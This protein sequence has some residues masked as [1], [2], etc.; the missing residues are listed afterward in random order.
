MNKNISQIG[1]QLAGIWKQLGL[2]QRISVVMA[3]AVT[4]LGLVGLA[5][6]SSRVDYALLYGKLDETEASK[7]IAALDEAKVPYKISRAGGAILVPSDKVYQLRM[8][9]AGK[10]IPRGEGVGF[11][12]FDKANFGISD[13]VQRANY[14]RAVQGE[15]AR[16]ISQLDQVESARVM[17]VMPEN[18]LL[19]DN[20]RKP[21]AS[22]FVRVKG[23]GQLP[24]SAVNSI[25]FLVANSVEG[26]QANNVSVVDNQGNVLSENQE[27]DSVAGL[28]G[29]Q[30]SARR[31]FEQY[32]TKKAE[33]MLEKVLGPGQAVV[34]VSA[35]INW[36]TITRTE[37]KFDPDGQVVRSSTINDE[38]TD[39][40]TTQSS[41]GAPGLAANSNTVV[42]SAAT[43]RMRTNAPVPTLNSSHTRKKV[44]NASY[45]INKT[46]SNI[47]QAAGGLKRISSAVFIAEKFDGKG[48]DRKAVPRTPEE[49][50]KIKRIVQS[51][52]GI[53]ENGD[54]N[55][56]D[57]ITLEEMPFNDQVSAEGDQQFDKQERLQFWLDLGK[58]LVYPALGI[59]F[60]FLFWRALKRI[61]VDDIPLGVPIG[62]GNGNGNG[63]GHGIGHGKG[64]VV[65]VEVL[66]QLIREN[67]ANMTQA[68]R[69]WLTK[70]NAANQPTE[71]PIMA[72]RTTKLELEIPAIEIG[73]MTKL[74]KLAGLLIIL[75]PESAAGILKNLNEHEQEAVSQEMAK[76][77]VISQEMQR[78]ILREFSEVAVQAST[79]VLGGVNYAKIVLEKSV[80]VF[81]AS[82]IISRVAPAPVPVASMQQ[83]IDMDARQLCNMLKNEQPQTIALIVSYFPPEK[84]SQ[85]LVLLRSELRDQVVERLATL[86]AYAG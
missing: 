15:L 59:L 56:K 57:E 51:A 42:R 14:T 82:D 75:G 5:Y 11:E 53:Q 18:R 8:Q 30:L 46:T 31:N 41:G 65:T 17:I 19:T 66:N 25:R 48:A 33:G 20:Q 73:K 63:N 43:I 26:L 74:Q 77:T 72:N 13:F 9:M 84:S 55:R 76:L 68:V 71:H 28:S 32:L 54:A 58:K 52:L 60:L 35:E 50:L 78:E 12:I 3:T 79:S 86:G 44:T 47:L 36:D 67:P 83:I 10:G 2:N 80:G 1:Q 29:N 4:V 38:N 22:I 64:G 24:A 49:L 61:K 69:G 27:N 7:V 45:E 39:T 62:N 34:R 6:W 37:E 40:A 21:T 16:T 81:R 23:N 85:I 70:T